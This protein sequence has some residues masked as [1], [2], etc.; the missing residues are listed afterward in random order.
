[1]ETSGAKKARARASCAI[2]APSRIDRDLSEGVPPYF[3]LL[4]GGRDF[5]S[6]TLIAWE[7]GM[8]TRL[9]SGADASLSLFYN[10]YDDLRSTAVNPVTFFPLFF[11]N[12]LEGETHGLEFSGTFQAR[13]WWR[14]HG[15]YSLLQ[16]HLHIRP[17]ET[18]INNALNETSDPE[19]RVSLRSSMDFPRRIGV[20]LMLRWVDIR[21][22]H[23]GPTP[24]ELPGYME[25]DTRLGW[26]T[27]RSVE[28]SLVGKNL[29]HGRHQEYGLPAATA[30]EIR[31]SL[32]G[33][34]T[35]RF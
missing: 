6:E 2:R 34:A 22:G 8:R 20:D 13:D 5:S 15:G 12:E 27:S 23:N 7:T 30:A 19:Q 26:K 25:L 9:G 31:R 35:W 29:L 10:K 17:G 3:D 28:L 14:L 16:E 24:G 4:N 11:Q 1:M 33:K 21:P 32:M 18:D